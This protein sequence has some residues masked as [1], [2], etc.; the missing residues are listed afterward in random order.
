MFG[1]AF[2]KNKA[3]TSG[4]FNPVLYAHK[5]NPIFNYATQVLPQID[6]MIESN[7]ILEQALTR[8]LALLG[9]FIK[10]GDLTA[11]A[12]PGNIAK[13]REQNSNFYY[14]REWR[15]VKEWKFIHSDVEAIMVPKN[16]FKD[17][18]VLLH[19]NGFE[20]IPIIPSE[21]VELL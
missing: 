16:I 12:L 6:K 20:G 4:E 18:R 3:I 19:A 17:A 2:N 7:P 9:T 21:M 14:E 13:D 11:P 8:Y 10:T 5:N 15:S 1:I